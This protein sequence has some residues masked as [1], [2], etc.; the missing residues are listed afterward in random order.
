MVEKAVKLL[1]SQLIK[2]INIDTN[3]QHVQ[4]MWYHKIRKLYKALRLMEAHKG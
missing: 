2:F 1:C 3:K 4:S